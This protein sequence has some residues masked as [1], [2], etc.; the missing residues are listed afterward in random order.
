MG[1]GMDRETHYATKIQLNIVRIWAVGGFLSTICGGANKHKH[2]K[3][4]RL[5]LLNLEVSSKHMSINQ[6]VLSSH[7]AVSIKHISLIQGCYLH[8]LTC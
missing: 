4:G 5:H 7:I 8:T 1:C 6:R 2:R 3:G